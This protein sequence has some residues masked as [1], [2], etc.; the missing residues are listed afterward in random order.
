MIQRLADYATSTRAL[1]G[2]SARAIGIATA[3]TTHS[4]TSCADQQVRPSLGGDPSASLARCGA[5]SFAVEAA[6]RSFH[7]SDHRTMRILDVFSCIISDVRRTRRRAR[8]IDHR[9]RVAGARRDRLS[10]SRFA[11][12]LQHSAN[13]AAGARQ[14]DPS[15]RRGL[16]ATDQR[17]SQ[18]ITLTVAACRS[19]TTPSRVLTMARA[20]DSATHRN[21]A[22]SLTYAD[23]DPCLRR[24]HRTLP[25]QP[26]NAPSFFPGSKPGTLRTYRRLHG[27]AARRNGRPRPPP[28]QGRLPGRGLP[29]RWWLPLTPRELGR[30]FSRSARRD[31]S[32]IGSATE[33]Q[34]AQRA[35]DLAAMAQRLGVRS[36]S[37]LR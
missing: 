2:P 17:A 23:H 30:R 5:A 35:R 28:H 26:N 12:V 13:G 19:A 4:S 1:G 16:N 36:A 31:P 10:A 6:D 37:C 32:I 9:Q 7:R 24:R 8:A 11:E 34:P 27:G 18:L 25:R 15:L 29:K 21:I 22:Q 3:T 33:D 14:S 20:M